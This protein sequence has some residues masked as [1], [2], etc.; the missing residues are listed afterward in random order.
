[1]PPPATIYGHLASAVGEWLDP[2]SLQFAYMFSFAAKGDDLEHQHIVSPHPPQ[3]LSHE[4]SA[5]LKDWRRRNELVAAGSVQPTIREFLFQ[6]ELT[7]YVQPASLALALRQPAFPVALGRSQDLASILSVEE[8][9][10]EEAVGAYLE[11]TLLPFAWRGRTAFGTTV[12]MPRFIGPP[13]ER[14]A[15]FAQYIVL[16]RRVYAGDAQVDVSDRARVVRQA[17]P[18]RWLVDPDS[19]AYSGVRRGIVF[20]SFVGE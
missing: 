8:V 14:Q 4:E 15:S 10:L 16:N 7:L 9:D 5:L 2:A 13:P 12:I 20:L 1:M 11:R 6:A 3:R 17:H 19:P 18:E